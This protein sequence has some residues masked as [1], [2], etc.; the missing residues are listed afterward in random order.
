MDCPTCGTTLATERGMRQ[1]HTKVHGDPLPNRTC[2]KFDVE[3]YDPKSRRVYCDDCYSAKGEMNGNWR[4]AKR[5]ATCQTCGDDFEYY[6]SD[7]EGVYCSA[8]VESAEGLLPENYSERVDRERVPCE[9]CGA[10]LERLLSDVRE[11]GYGQFCDADCYGAWLSENVVGEDHHQWEGGTL[12]YGKKWWRVR[13]RALERDEYTCQH[14]GETEE[15]L[16]R[17]PDVH[18]LRRVRDF[19][20]PQDAHTL[21]N[22]VTLC[23]PCHRYVESGAVTLDRRK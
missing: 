9:H 8:C 16:D 7:K 17:N 3:F 12:D 20:D 2:E 21:E 22:V 19:D 6:P 4:G 13:R 10:E 11:E 23:R 5:T 18:H 15:Q 1:H 14:C